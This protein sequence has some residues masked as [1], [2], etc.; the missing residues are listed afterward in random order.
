MMAHE[1]ALILV[2]IMFYH[3]HDCWVAQNL[4]KGHKK[5][6]TTVYALRRWALSVYLQSAARLYAEA[7]ARKRTKYHPTTFLSR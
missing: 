1:K 6:L 2:S 7:G 5:G 3:E 4:K